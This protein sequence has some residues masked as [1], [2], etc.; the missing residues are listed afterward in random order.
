MLGLY[1]LHTHFLLHK[2]NADDT[3]KPKQCTNNYR[4]WSPSYRRVEYLRKTEDLQK[5]SDI[6]RDRIKKLD[7]GAHCIKNR[8]K[9]F[10]SK[11]S[12]I[13]L[14][15]FNMFLSDVSRTEEKPKQV[16]SMPEFGKKFSLEVVIKFEKNLRKTDKFSSLKLWFSIFKSSSWIFWWSQSRTD[17]KWGSRA[18]LAPRWRQPC[19]QHCDCNKWRQTCRWQESPVQVR[20]EL[21]K[22]ERNVAWLFATYNAEFVAALVEST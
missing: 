12:K 16:G 15:K 2:S 1:I 21:V 4:C 10:L 17:F 9:F 18:S 3:R 11:A 13:K 7:E 6:W 14:L 20:L 8:Y 19:T 5:A 22:G